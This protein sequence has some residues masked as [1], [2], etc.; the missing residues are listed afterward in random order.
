MANAV[1]VAKNKRPPAIASILRNRANGL[2]TR[3]A[4]SEGRFEDA[5]S[6]IYLPYSPFRIFPICQRRVITKLNMLQTGL[7]L[8]PRLF[9]RNARIHYCTRQRFF[10]TKRAMVEVIFD[11]GAV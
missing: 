9:R 2:V 1:I 7:D 5:Q 11:V 8:N 3:S 6:V 10:E 4:I